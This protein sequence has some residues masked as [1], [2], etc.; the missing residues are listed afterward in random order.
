M[1]R[2]NKNFQA[3]LLLFLRFFVFNS[4]AHSCVHKFNI[5]ELFSDTFFNLRRRI[6]KQFGFNFVY[7]TRHVAVSIMNVAGNVYLNVFSPRLYPL[8]VRVSSVYDMHNKQDL[9]GSLAQ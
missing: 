4:A 8:L 1:K 6:V 2:V 9:I 5:V 3:F 7:T